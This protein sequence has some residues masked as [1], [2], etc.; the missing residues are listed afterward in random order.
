MLQRLGE[1]RRGSQSFPLCGDTF[2]WA[3]G[4]LPCYLFRLS[5]DWQLRPF[6][7]LAKIFA[8]STS[9]ACA[10]SVD[11]CSIGDAT[12]AS[13]ALSL[14]TNVAQA[15]LAGVAFVTPKGKVVLVVSDTGHFSKPFAVKYH[16]EAFQT[17]MPAESLGSL[18]C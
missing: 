1:T 4:M 6:P 7:F 2:N 13:K 15:A 12:D 14:P 3:F 10:M 17:V 8:S 5:P 18:L 11:P 16:S 9:I